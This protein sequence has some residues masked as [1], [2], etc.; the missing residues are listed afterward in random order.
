MD[1][2]HFWIGVDLSDGQPDDS[3][4][5]ASCLTHDDGT[6]EIAVTDILS[7]G[8]RATLADRLSSYGREGGVVAR[9]AWLVLS[10]TGAQP[11]Q[12]DGLA[13]ALDLMD[14][15]LAVADDDELEQ[16]VAGACAMFARAL[17]D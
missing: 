1:Y 15:H 12:T 8:F 2:Q 7:D 4:A 6:V 16:A 14:G 13:G 10:G 5:I 17:A 11:I 9:H 3:I